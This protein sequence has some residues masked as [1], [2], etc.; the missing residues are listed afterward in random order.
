MKDIVTKIVI[1]IVFLAME[2]VF[3]NWNTNQ[4][5]MK[6]DE[7]SEITGMSVLYEGRRA[8]GDIDTVETLEEVI[9]KEDI[10]GYYLKMESLEATG[11][12]KLLSTDYEGIVSVGK[13]FNIFPRKMFTADTFLPTVY[14]G[15]YG[16]FYKATLQDGNQV[17]L[18]V[19][20]NDIEDVEAGDYSN[21]VARYHNGI[22][23]GIENNYQNEVSEQI[24]QLE[25]SM[26][27]K[28]YINIADIT[29]AQRHD[30]GLFMMSVLKAFV[31]AIIAG[32][33]VCVINIFWKD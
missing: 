2:V 33:V 23:E 11:L 15:M 22:V 8:K 25:E 12:Y 28:G 7:V 31:A 29:W 9:A 20:C 30:F 16:Q 14:R 13:T 21:I 10:E 17:L 4:Y 26:S 3:I 24:Q 27:V 19:G 18:L 1:I 5:L 32:I 6:G